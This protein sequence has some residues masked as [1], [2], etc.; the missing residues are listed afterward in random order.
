[1]SPRAPPDGRKIRTEGLRKVTFAFRY[2]SLQGN[3]GRATGP[4]PGCFPAANVW[5]HVPAVYACS[6]AGNRAFETF[7]CRPVG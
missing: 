3:P 1:M 7:L 4:H 6:S 2:R 5:H